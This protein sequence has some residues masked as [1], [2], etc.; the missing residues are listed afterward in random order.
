MLTCDVCKNAFE[1]GKSYKWM[2]GKKIS[3]YN[4]VK[5]RYGNFTE[6]TVNCCSKCFV[7]LKKK[8]KKEVKK[9]WISLLISLVVAPLLTFMMIKLTP[10]FDKSKILTIIGILGWLLCIFS[11]LLFIFTIWAIIKN[12][13]LKTGSERETETV[14]SQICLEKVHALGLTDYWTHK[15][16]K[17]VNVSLYG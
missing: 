10:V 2:A 7:E 9:L 13:L 6:I 12:F 14:L 5:T 11:I 17:W 3:A 1:E 4:E 16:F 15:R 8:Y